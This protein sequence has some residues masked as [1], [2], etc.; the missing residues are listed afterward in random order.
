MT[1]KRAFALL[2]V[3]T[4]LLLTC[5][6]SAGQ[7]EDAVAAPYDH[8][9]V[10]NPNPMRGDFGLQLWGE[11]TSDMDISYL[12][13][14][15][16]LVYWDYEL[17]NFDFDPMVVSGVNPK[18]NTE[19][20]REYDIVLKEDLQYS[21][22]TPITAWDYAYSMLLQS[23]SAVAE[24]GANTQP[25]KGILGADE[26]RNGE[27]NVLKGVRV[28]NDYLM[29]I[30]VSGAF[31]PYYYELRFLQCNPV[32]ISETAPGCTVKD[33]GEGVYLDGEL[34]AELLQKT[35]LDPATGYV[36][37]PKITSGPYKLISFDG[38]VAELEKND[39]YL[40]SVSEKTPMIRYLTY[41]DVSNT[42]MVKKLATGEIDLINKAVYSDVIAGGLTLVKN[43]GF[44]MTSYER[45]GASFAGF[46]CEKPTVSDKLV[47][48]AIA[49]CVDKDQLIKEYL[50]NYGIATE[51]YYGIGQWMY[52][53]AN[54]S[55]ILDAAEDV[56]LMYEDDESTMTCNTEEANA[57][58]DEAGWTLNKA[59]D[60]YTGAKGEI[61]SKE[62]DGELVSLELLMVCPAENDLGKQIKACMDPQL[63]QVGISLE[64]RE[65]PWNEI[66]KDYYAN[67]NRDCDM[68]VVATN[69]ESAFEAADAFDPNDLSANYSRIQDEELYQSVWSINSTSRTAGEYVTTWYS[70][71]EKFMDVLPMIPLY[72]NIYYDFYTDC[73]HDY[74]PQNVGTWGE[75][76]MDAFLS[77]PNVLPEEMDD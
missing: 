25:F 48:H 12:I 57:L 72:S 34:T 52:K 53:A 28:Y 33:D 2:T 74:Y 42:D 18:E 76:M 20:D 46:C 55:Q 59:G 35:L 26:Y 47:R 50:G 14:G 9:R 30:T 41:T 63:A 60:P 3:L 68:Y 73:L 54:G 7:A 1:L 45:S 22:G 77:D 29:T 13:N 36:T 49:C 43:G 32:P 75:A 44:A 8:L 58:L 27:T 19:G 69:F 23:S 21:D 70:F 66:R 6:L 64:I 51:G 40:G 5:G 71:Q 31:R 38:K 61:R 67:G 11:G 65:V 16:G 24:L 37:H 56:K 10:G 15:Y 4:M 39:L 17:N 62:I